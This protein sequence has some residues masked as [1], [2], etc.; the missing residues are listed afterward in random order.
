VPPSSNLGH[1]PGDVAQYPVN[2]ELAGKRCLVVGAGN[3][4]IRKVRGLVAA[5]ALVSVVAPEVHTSIRALSA[6]LRDGAYRASITVIERCYWK[7]DLDGT[8]LV[9]TCTD[10]PAVNHQVF[11][12]AEAANVWSNSA[13]DP[14]NCAFTLP[15]VVRQGDLQVTASTRGRSPALS[16][17]LRHRFEADFDA[18]WS[19]LLDLLA[20]VRSELQSVRGTSEVSGWLEALDEGVATLVLDGDVVA[21]RQL[22]R[23]HLGLVAL[24][25]RLAVA[26]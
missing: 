1:I 25:E 21:A 16:M 3:V 18:R 24:D 23:R 8:R 15:S 6:E 17:W 19:D 26:R 20:D 22:L 13:D 2:L 10:D 9:I 5:G 11:V 14:V 7:H 12:D 4:A